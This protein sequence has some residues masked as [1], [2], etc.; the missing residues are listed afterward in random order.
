MT[1]AKKG[2]SS[3]SDA[4]LKKLLLTLRTRFLANP[5]RHPDLA[6]SD[7]EAKI[8]SNPVKANSL[9]AM[10]ST[11]GEPDVLGFD[12]STEQFIF[13][14]CSLESPGSRRSLCYDQKALNSRKE[15]KPKSS[16]ME[17]ATAIGI[18]LLTEEQYRYLQTLGHFDT[19]TS[20]WVKTPE[21]VRNLGGAIFCDYRFGRVFTY[22]N[23]AESYYAARG[24]RGVLR[25]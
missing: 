12:K 9:N 1:A 17:F 11:G 3:L 13:F 7:V 10:E 15:N 21:C 19:K 22:H 5:N 24:F 6:W 16:A 14:D 4:D 2:P 8:I 25:V 18:E 23:G 20:S